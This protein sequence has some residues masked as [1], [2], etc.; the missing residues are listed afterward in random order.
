MKFFLDSANISDFNN[1]KDYVCGITTNPILLKKNGYN[2]YNEYLKDLDK[3]FKDC[4]H[5]IFL[6]EHSEEKIIE[7]IMDLNSFKN[8]QKSNI[9]W[10][11]PAPKIKQARGFEEVY[12]CATMTFNIFQLN[13][14]IENDF[15]FS[16][17]LFSKNENTDFPQE[18]VM[19]RSISQSNIL[20]IA[21]SFRNKGEVKKAMLLGY[22]YATIPP[23]ILFDIIGQDDQTKKEYFAHYGET[24]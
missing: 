7:T 6:Q 22:E 13:D 20:L 17:V 12:Y 9:I 15:Q 2:S 21:A 8:I 14:A 18:A 23:N 10:K 3:S 24:I 11:I 5:L 19:L 1:Y 16:I 4:G